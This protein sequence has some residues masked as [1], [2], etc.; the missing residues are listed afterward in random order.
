MFQVNYV[1]KYHE[2][3]T[4]VTFSIV[5][6]ILWRSAKPSEVF[7]PLNQI[8]YFRSED[9]EPELYPAYIALAE[10]MKKLVR[11]YCQAGRLQRRM[12]VCEFSPPRKPLN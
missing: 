3:V 6:K 7:L 2:F 9:F 12:A 11:D 5:D 10:L 4:P 8:G 1:K